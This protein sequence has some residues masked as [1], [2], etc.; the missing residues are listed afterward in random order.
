MEEELKNTLENAIQQVQFV[1]DVKYVCVCKASW[2]SSNRE[3]ALPSYLQSKSSLN[4]RLWL[5]PKVVIRLANIEKCKE[6]C[7]QLE[8]LLGPGYVVDVCPLKSDI[9]FDENFTIFVNK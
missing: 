4:I 5:M 9:I 7:K 8:Q 1:D 2:H 6:S 3:K